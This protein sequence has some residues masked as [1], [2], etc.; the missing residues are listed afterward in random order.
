MPEYSFTLI[1][2]GDV[3]ARL[4][5][6]FEAGCDDATFGTVDSVH[7]ADFDREAASLVEAMSAAV[8]AIES[9]PGLRVSRIEPD[10]LVTAS[11]IAKRLGRTRES[12]R[13]LIAGA[14]GPGTF[15]APIS[16]L[17]GVH[18]LWRWSD[19]AAWACRADGAT[20]EQARLVA[21]ANAALELRARVAALGEDERAFVSRL[22]RAG[23]A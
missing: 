21:A 14:R 12:V 20:V 9:V 23:T 7:Y 22:E 8:T 11:E 15:P 16:H 17:A 10:D 1:I 5:E 18:R 6:L 13:L 19:V 2:Q 4:D 3:D